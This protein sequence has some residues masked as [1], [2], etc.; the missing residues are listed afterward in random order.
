M[1]NL[2]KALGLGLLLCGIARANPLDVPVGG[3]KIAAPTGGN[4]ANGYFS[5]TSA[6]TV[7]L[8]TPI[9]GYQYCI[10]HIVVTSPSA[11][12]FNMFWS[13]GTLLAATT[14]Y[15]V[16]VAANTP[17]IDSWAYRTPYCAPP[18]DELTLYLGVAS[19]T[20]TFEGYT[21]AGWNKP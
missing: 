3:N 6:S 17:Y 2:I 16:G 8:S 7:V 1:K 11:G 10:T 21:F 12:L 18:G 20:M 4:Q 13:S 14:D 5:G 9:A 15:S 19:S